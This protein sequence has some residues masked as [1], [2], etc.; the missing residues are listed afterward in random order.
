M[1]ISQKLKFLL[2]ISLLFY[3]VFAFSQLSR[4]YDNGATLFEQGDFQGAKVMMS[5]VIAKS[6]VYYEAYTIRGRSYEKLGM[7]DSALIDFNKALEIKPD[8]LPAIFFRGVLN[9]NLANWELAK[10]DFDIILKSRPDYINALIYRGRSLEELGKKEEAIEDYTTAIN[11]RLKNHEVYYRRGLLYEKERRPKDA[12]WDFDKSV[13]Y[14][15][16][17]VEGYLH[18][19]KMNQLL[20]NDA[21]ALADF[22][23]VLSLTDTMREVYMDRG[24]LNFKLKNYENAAADYSVL[25]D[26]FRVK[27]GNLYFKR[28][29]AYF[30]DSNYSAAFKEYTRVLQ[31][32]PRFDPAIV[33]QAKIRL[34][35]GKPSSALPLL[36]KALSFNPTNGEAYFLKGKML[37]E[38]EKFAEALIDL[39]Q[40][41]K[42]FPKAESY[43]YRGSARFET[44]D[45][46]GACLDLQEAV[47]QGYKVEGIED[48]VKRVCN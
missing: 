22:D 24:D 18:R 40:A 25:I 46:Y 13:M 17:F 37:Y 9:Y 42:Y 21:E 36:R 6:S 2:L 30:L 44:G 45:K 16:D 11:L 38:Q 23:K 33:A 8:F 34:I 10:T 29:D 15:S 4:T 39:N 48:M 20:G 31:V 3:S 47:K 19:G 35:E 28:A 27:D 14:K 26:K 5:R 43:F 7:P 12:L 32:K 1:F 41:V